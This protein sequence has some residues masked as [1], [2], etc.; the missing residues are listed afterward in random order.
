MLIA[1][2]VHNILTT[3]MTNIGVNKSTDNAEPRSICFFTTIFN[4]KKVFISER[5]QNYH[6]KK[7]QAL[8]ITIS[9]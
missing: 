6:I 7:E 5:D 1:S 2:W 3:V 4:A 8:S 9:Q